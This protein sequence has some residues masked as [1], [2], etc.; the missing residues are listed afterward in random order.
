MKKES[1]CGKRAAS[2]IAALCLTV[3]SAFTVSAEPPSAE[4]VLSVTVSM[5]GDAP[6][7]P[8]AYTVRMTAHD[9]APLPDGSEGYFDLAVTGQGSADFPPIIYRTVGVYRYT[10]TQIAGDDRDTSYD[11]SVYDVTV[12]VTNTENGIKPTVVLSENGEKHEAL[13]FVD[14]YE[15]KPLGGDDPPPPDDPPGTLTETPEEPP[16]DIPPS[17]D[18]PTDST[19]DPSDG[20]AIPDRPTEGTNDQPH[21]GLIQTGQ[22]NLPVLVTAASGAVLAMIG[23][24]LIRKRDSGDR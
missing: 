5:T 14:H 2:F 17:D 1:R 3:V 22:H 12:T 6:Y 20:T 15:H 11:G 16:T 8:E 21:G 24:I 23:V 9:G 13:T 7:V 4:V 18:P 10:V 19:D